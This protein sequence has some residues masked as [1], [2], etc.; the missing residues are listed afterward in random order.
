MLAG[1]RPVVVL[2]DLNVDEENAA[3]AMLCGAKDADGWRLIDSYREVVPQRDPNEA[4]F[5][6]FQG[7]KAGSRIDFIL[8]TEGFRATQA[9][10]DR[11]D[12]DGRYPS[13]HYPVTAVLVPAP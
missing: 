8:H 12:F 6:A 11:T 7:K 10:I 5:H 2:G 13:D 1:N 9:G 3:L 4:T